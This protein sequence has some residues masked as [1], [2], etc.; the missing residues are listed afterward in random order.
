MM[1]VFALFLFAGAFVLV[2][3]TLT[4]STRQ[5]RAALARA[6]AFGDIGGGA[7]TVEPEAGSS[8]F[9]NLRET[10]GGFALCV[11]PSATIESITLKLVEAG[12]ARRVSPMSFL[13]SK[14]LLAAAGIFLGGL[15]AVSAADARGIL[16]APALGLAGFLLPDLF[17]MT[18]NR[19]RRE[20]IQQQLPRRARSARGQRRGGPDVRRRGR[21]ARRVHGGPARRG[22]FADPPRD[23]NRSE[24]PKRL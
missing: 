13:A 24:P 11:T 14:S 1:L 8:T 3:E 10:L 18:R 17:V 4:R 12:V 22:V 23:A 5:R 6:R 19:S 21:E 7:T 20:R 15:V 16:L 2:A 9:A